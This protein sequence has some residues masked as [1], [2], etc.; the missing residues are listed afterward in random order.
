VEIRET[1]VSRVYLV[2]PDV[3]K[4]KKAVSLGFLDYSTLE[5]RR[6]MC[7][8]E[9][10]LNRRLAP[11]VYLGVEKVT[12]AGS[13]FQLGGTGRAVDY[14]VHMR[15]LPD[16]RMLTSLIEADQAGAADLEQVGR[17]LAAFH[18]DAAR[19]P[20][21][22]RFGLP[23]TIA[24][25]VEENF[26]QVSP[27]VG[28]ALTPAAFAAVATFARQFLRDQRDLLLDRVAAG[29]VC[30]GHGDLR[31]DH[32]YL[33]G[34]IEVIDCIEFN[35]RFRYGDRAADLAFLVM[36]LAAHGRPDLAGAL[37][38]GYRG[39]LD[40][41]AG[42]VMDF[43]CCYRAFTR[44]KVACIRASQAPGTPGARDAFAEARRYFHLALRY[45][46]GPRRPW[47]AVMCGLTGTGKTTL[48]RR[49]AG[50][51]AAEVLS[52]D[53]I[54]KGL[55][56]L[57]PTA[58]RPDQLDDGLYSEEMNERVYRAMRDSARGRLAEGRD[59]ILDATYRR[60]GDRLAARA[61]AR[62]MG[63]DFLAVECV[64][65]PE[66]VRRRLAE[67]ARDPSNWSDGR[68]E[69]YLAQREAFEPLDELSQDERLRVDT[70]LPLERQAEEVLG[71]LEAALSARV[72]A[73]RESAAC[74]GR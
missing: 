70:E 7:E 57:A 23:E 21:I 31:T 34:G 28:R 53:P 33:D 62:E 68:W 24:A 74:A 5:Q 49:L 45:A 38:R 36:D 59:V 16:E 55:A 1:H 60:R 8:L 64:T 13:S 22:D 9:V 42:A 69:V 46:S 67:R 17:R 3:Y 66:A 29:C 14:L 43:Y 73:G 41:D 72:V 71:A 32:V 51:L 56:G 26:D 4:L 15:R 54:R 27:F 25:N 20:A 39:L 65:A 18:R 30:D 2:G 52:A 12:R 44:G 48:A 10:E 6:R 40:D 63:A 61:L 58:A 47:L 11:S 35:D 19:G 50:L 37:L